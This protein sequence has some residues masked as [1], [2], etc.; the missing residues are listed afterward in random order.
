MKL[1]MATFVVGL[2]ILMGSYRF[3]RANHIEIRQSWKEIVDTATIKLPLLQGKINP[4]DTHESLATN[5]KEGDRVEI[6][7]SYNGLTKNY[8]YN[9][10]KG[11]VKRVSPEVPMVIE[12]EDAGYWFKRVNLQKTW[13]N[14]TLKEVV[15]YVV[16]EVNKISGD[17]KI[18]LSDKIPDVEFE[19]F[20]LASANGL[21]ALQ[22]IKDNFGLVSYFNDLELFAGL[23]YTDLREEVNYSTEWNIIN[24]QNLKIRNAEDTKIKLK[25]VSILKNNKKIEIEV[26]DSEGEQRTKFYYNISSEATLKK[27]AEQDLN[28]FKFDG[29]EG[30]FNTF[31]IPKVN[32]SDTA[33]IV[34]PRFSNKDGKYIIDEV[35]TTLD[36]GIE[37]KITI[38]KKVS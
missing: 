1:I 22:Q 21:E 19:K 9:E 2:E 32:H 4:N 33:N 25:A 34:D 20:R 35:V 37:R 28:T 30:D 5:I 8:E 16:D 18:T 27:L 38:G 15:Q 6:Q 36:T 11:F 24:S 13:R 3:T 26:G 10:F 29:L 17:Y 12:C 7:L 23:A 14:T 31:L